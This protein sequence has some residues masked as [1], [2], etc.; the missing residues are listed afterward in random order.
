M[1][2]NAVCVRRVQIKKGLNFCICTNLSHEHL[3]FSLKTLASMRNNHFGEE[4]LMLYIVYHKIHKRR[5]V[6]DAA[7]RVSPHEAPPFSKT[8]DY[9]AS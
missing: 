3:I 1:K 7:I 2:S 5:L 4:G 6:Q 9:Q 8:V